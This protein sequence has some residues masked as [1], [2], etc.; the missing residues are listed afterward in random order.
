M[1]ERATQQV[2]GGPDDPAA[3]FG[4]LDNGDQ[5]TS[6]RRLLQTLPDHAEVVTGQRCRNTPVP[7]TGESEAFRL[8]NAVPRGSL[9][10]SGRTALRSRR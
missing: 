4:P 5:L 8:A 2:P 10:A 1:A 6:V 3:D 9:S 7:F